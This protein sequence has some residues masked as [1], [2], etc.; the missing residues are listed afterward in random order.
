MNLLS[1]IVFLILL[2]LGIPWFWP[3]GSSVLIFGLPA[4]VISAIVVSIMCSVFT[5]FLLRKP[6]THEKPQEEDE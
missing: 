1:P 3:T 4:W 5:A 2:A 6:W